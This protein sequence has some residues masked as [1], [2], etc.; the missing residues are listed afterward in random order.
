MVVDLLGESIP[1]SR[2]PR[3]SASGPAYLSLFM[4]AAPCD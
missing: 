3:G 4:A 1:R 2:V